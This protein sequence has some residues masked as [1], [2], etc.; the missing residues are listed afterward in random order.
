MTLDASGRLGIG[1][2]APDARLDVLGTSDTADVVRIRKSSTGSRRGA[3]GTQSGAGC[4]DLYN[5]SSALSIK[6]FAEGN[7]YFN[8]GNVGIGTT[9][10]VNL[11]QVSRNAT[12]DTAIVVSNTG[13]A[14]STTTMSFV[15]QE[16]DVP[17][18]WF[19][20][21]RDG[22]AITE[23]GFSNDFVFAGNIQSSKSERMRITSGGNVGIGL[24]NPDS[25]FH[26]GQSNGSQIRI[27]FVG[28]GENFYDGVTQYFRNGS[29]VATMTLTNSGNVGIGTT[30]PTQ[31]LDV[32][33]YIRATS[34]FVGNGGLSLWG[35]NN[36]SS[37]GLF[38]TTDGNVGIGTTSPSERLTVSG[39]GFFIGSV[40]ADGS[41]N[42]FLI[43]Q[44]GGSA[45]LATYSANTDRAQIAFKFAQ[46]FPGENNYTRVLDIVSTGDATGGG[47]IRFLTTVNNS[48]P[49]TS[50]YISPSGNVGIGT[51]S[52]SERLTVSGN[53]LFSGTTAFLYL[54]NTTP[55][56]G[57]NWRFSSAAN[58][59]FF[60][61]QDGVVD[62]LQIAQTTGAAT[63]SSSVTASG[64]TANDATY[65][66]V[67]F[68]GGT[69]NGVVGSF[70]NNLRLINFTSAG[71]TTIQG[72]ADVNIIS[73]GASNITLGTSNTERMRITSGGNVGIG[74]TSPQ[75]DLHIYRTGSTPTITTG[76]KVNHECN[77]DDF[78]VF[79]TG[80]ESAATN[81]FVML[82]GGNVGIGTSSPAYKL[83]VSS[84][85]RFTGGFY[86][87]ESTA[88]TNSAIYLASDQTLELE[89][90]GTNGAIAFSTSS[91]VS[92]R[93]RITSS[94]NV[95]IG[96]TSP[97]ALLDVNGTGRFTGNLL[98]S[99]TS[100]SISNTLQFVPTN[101]NGEIRGQFILQTVADTSV[102][103]ND[104]YR[105]KVAA[106][107]G[108][109][110]SGN[111]N[112][113]LSFLRTTR[114]GVTDETVFT[115]NGYT[116]AATFSNSVTATAFFASSDITLKNIIKTSYNPTG[117]E[118]IS[119]KWKDSGIDTKVHVGYSAQQVQE[120]MPDAVSKDSNGKLSVNYVEVLVA[121]IASLEAEVK[122]LK[123]QIN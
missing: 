34:G 41:G 76:L 65:G 72:N 48:T 94:G 116:G 62:A 100:T 26:V 28:S 36:S 30:S 98:V 31:R 90:F 14:S 52:P 19:R 42:G 64:F 40:R 53:G 68:T 56:T 63:F 4:L 93:M 23:I 7:S 47:A 108:A 67:N 22:S 92:E 84:V 80:N 54:N 2:T 85:S 105:W 79:F 74:T 29:G 119:Y 10:P 59:N 38:V 123:A 9:S 97:S 37:A 50:M 101:T 15:L 86:L 109:G 73:V 11:L 110:N 25:K 46:N 117:I 24:S 115:L 43:N 33:G 78:V 120:F 70:G 13:T 27:D 69:S 57:K 3:L 75:A 12:S 81:R 60:I 66:A 122:L 58:G 77:A 18:G 99:T 8:G 16:L 107:G 35:D 103:T 102:N 32:N 112:S 121:K 113:N 17:N 118:A 96:T 82:Q 91:S 51:T 88:G 114:N 87:N 21:Y 49:A 71:I 45:G 89:A 1:I 95:G 111:W 83:D 104:A 55:T 6:L 61:T 20:R 44:N 5:D 106:V 39:N